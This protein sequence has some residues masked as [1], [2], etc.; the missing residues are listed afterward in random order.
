MGT[1]SLTFVYDEVLDGEY[2][3]Q[4]G[5]D[6]Q[7]TKQVPII[8]M[9][10]QYDGYIDGHGKELAEFLKPIKIINGIQDNYKDVAN[11]MGCL[12]AQLITHF[13]TE[14]GRGENY[15][16]SIYLHNPNETD[17]WQNYEYH[18]YKGTIR[19]IQHDNH[20]FSGTWDEFFDFCQKPEKDED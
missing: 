14:H 3:K 12:A 10:R 1:R 4:A 6:N 8:N 16:G 7:K 17:C 2:D 18:V 19:V 15:I 13:K 11:G 20:L 9:Y 5:P